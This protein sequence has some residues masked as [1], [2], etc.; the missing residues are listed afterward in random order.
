MTISRSTLLLILACATAPELAAQSAAPADTPPTVHIQSFSVVV[1]D[2]E[3]ARQWYTEKLG[4][5]V[6]MDQPIPGGERFLMVAPPG[7]TDFGIV[8]QKPVARSALE[9]P[10]PDYSDRIGKVVNVVLRVSDVAGYARA[11][12]RNG[13]VLDSGPTRM[14]WGAQATFRDLFGNTFVIVGPAGDA[15]E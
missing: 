15:H 8:L 4:F 12:E 9:G 2:Y 6:T 3:P 5:V 10:M 11:I 14:P 1:P 7:Q 13:V